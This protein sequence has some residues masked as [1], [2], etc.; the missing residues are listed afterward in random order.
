MPATINVT[1]I[2][3]T[4]FIGRRI[5]GHLIAS[6]YEVVGTVRPHSRRAEQLPSGMTKKVAVLKPGDHG[7]RDALASADAV[8]YAAGAVRGVSIDDFRPANVHGL[9]AVAQ[10]IEELPESPRLLLLSSLAASEPRLSAYA[11]SKREGEAALEGHPGLASSIFRPPAVYGLGDREMRPLFDSIR[12]GIAPRT[13]PP[14][15]RLSLLHVDDLCRAVEAW[16]Q[17]DASRLPGCLALHD[18]RDGGYR[19]DE[20]VEAVSPGKR[21]WQIPLPRSVLATAA[22]VNE[23]GCRLTGRLPMLSSGKVGELR[24]PHWVCD[25]AGISEA[26]DWRPEISLREGI[27]GLY[28]S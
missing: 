4:G 7:L 12:R 8:I 27:E 13:G 23:A 18:G 6:G 14:G 5:A 16:L 1:L 2:G 15:Q 3:A 26:L 17:C 9:G 10:V 11:R 19:F 21:V 22:L 24:H 25:N 20:I 28:S